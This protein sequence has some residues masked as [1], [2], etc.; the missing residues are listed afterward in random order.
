MYS[1]AL[2]LPR[3]PKSTFFLWGPRQSGKSSLLKAT[4][5]QALRIDLL[6]SEEFSQL[7]SRPESLRE[8]LLS[9]FGK[10]TARR[11]VII[12]EFQRVPALLNEVHH[13]IED[14]GFVFSLCGSSA[15]K[16]KS[17]HANLLGGRAVRYGLSGLT[18]H[19]LGKDFDLERA[20]N[21]G[22]LP[23]VYGMEDWAAEARPAL[24]AYCADYLKEEI[25]AEG[26]VR[27]LPT[28]SR[29]LE[30]AALSDGEILSWE[31][32]ARDVG[33]SAP[34]I[35]T[36]F[37]ILEETLIGSVLPAYIQRPKR[38]TI[39]SSKFYFFDVG[40]VNQLAERGYIKPKSELFGKAFENWV[41]HEL[42][43]YLHVRQLPQKL[44][45]WRLTTGVE[46]DFIVGKIACA[47]EAKASQHITSDH[48]KGLRELLKEYPSA[49]NRV[50]V[51]L[52]QKSRLTDDGIQ[53]LSFA[54]FCQRLW[55][56]ELFG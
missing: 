1:R 43:T 36:Y 51:S 8:R 11:F 50:V 35:R 24:E 53:I 16:L 39:E 29:F 32:F 19:E 3:E 15:R 54:D 28:F 5:P 49:K 18:S 46:V 21:F 10:S 34:T 44:S 9:H 4:Y 33:V 47:I 56:G 20:L 14:H 23:R 38:R 37:E 22:G 40:V 30:C 26:I 42:Q 25:H 17:G 6:K 52:E 31:S 55:A 48:T 12:D 2:R 13:L 27:K 45:H 41:H 7:A